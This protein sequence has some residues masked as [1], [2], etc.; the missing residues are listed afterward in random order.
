MKGSNFLKLLG[1]GSNM[2]IVDTDA[3]RNFFSIINCHFMFKSDRFVFSVLVVF[4][5]AVVY[6]VERL[7]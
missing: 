2:L 5:H 1:S 4:I 6:I 3:Y 7:D